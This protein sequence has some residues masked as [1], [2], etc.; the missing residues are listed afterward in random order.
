MR[1]ERKKLPGT[2][3]QHIKSLGLYP[4]A[5][6]ILFIYLFIYFC[7]LGGHM[8]VPRL[9]AKSELQLPAYATATAT[10]DLSQVC[11]LPHISLQCQIPNPQSEARDRTCNLLVPRQICFRCATMGPPA[12]TILISASATC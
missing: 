5:Q 8:E 6:A 7:F 1:L 3:L 4:T 9:G 10:Q 12:E 11:N 2:L